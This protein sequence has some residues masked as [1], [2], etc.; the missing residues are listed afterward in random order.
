[1]KITDIEVYSNDIQFM[2]FSL[3]NVKTSDEYLIK[4]I[5]GLDAENIIPVYYGSG[6][7]SKD[8]FYDYIMKPRDIVMKIGLNPRFNFNE[9]YEELRDKIYRCIS[10]SRSGIISLKF[11]SKATALSQILGRIIKFEATHFTKEPEVQI[12]FNCNEP[13]FK[14]INRTVRTGINET[15]PVLISDEESSA[16]HGSCVKLTFNPPSSTFTMQD[17]ATDP[18]WQFVVTPASSFVSGDI[19]YFSSEKNNRY[20]YVD[21][22]A[23][24][25]YLTDKISPGSIWPILFPGSNSFHIPEIATFDWNQVDYYASYWGV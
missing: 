4:N 24:I 18:E 17:T 20:L 11:F 5:V 16:P 8:K 22:A 19:L 13:L 7:N 1:M 21:R 23:A 25:T 15:N 14:G 2:K 6:A 10:A 9:S 12:T 3:E